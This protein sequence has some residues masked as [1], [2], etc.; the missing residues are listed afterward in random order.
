MRSNGVGTTALGQVSATL[1]T[2]LFNEYTRELS[3]LA[4]EACI[5]STLRFDNELTLKIEGFSDSIVNFVT[6]YLQKLAE[7]EKSDFKKSF[8][9]L[10]SKQ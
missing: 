5:S 2:S 6:L 7:F 10:H 9:I 4:Y 3:Y 1:W 8:E